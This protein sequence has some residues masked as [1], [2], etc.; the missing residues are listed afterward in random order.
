[1]KME[2]LLD[3]KK[4]EMRKILEQRGSYTK[5]QLIEALKNV[6]LSND[7]AVKLLHAYGDMESAKETAQNVWNNAWNSSNEVGIDYATDIRKSSDTETRM[8][9][10]FESVYSR[11][12]FLMAIKTIDPNEINDELLDKLYE[13]KISENDITNHVLKTT[14]HYY[15]ESKAKDAKLEDYASRVQSRLTYLERTLQQRESDYSKLSTAYQNLKTKFQERIASNEKHYQEARRQVETLKGKVKQMQERGFFKIIGDKL[16]GLFANTKKL[17]EP[18][19]E[20]PETLLKNKCEI[21]GMQELDENEILLMDS[22]MYNEQD[23]DRTDDELQ[24]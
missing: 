22:R 20:L 10:Y 5:E 15:S 16:N 23:V 2:E 8:T 12:A 21:I 6:G 11:C 9:Q 3:E 13:E 7:S 19:F 4:A 18:G 14:Y 24:H 1:M 17:T